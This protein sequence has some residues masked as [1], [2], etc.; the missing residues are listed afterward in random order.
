MPYIDRAQRPKLDGPIDELLDRINSAGQLNY[1]VTRLARGFARA[2]SYERYNTAIG[3]LECAKLELYR[4]PIAR[5]E[6]AKKVANGDVATVVRKPCCDPEGCDRAG[7]CNGT[8]LD[9]TEQVRA[10]TERIKTH[11]AIPSDSLGP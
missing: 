11:A 3:V 4:G 1:V 9:R 8:H 6:D 2:P 10:A 5:Y 7:S